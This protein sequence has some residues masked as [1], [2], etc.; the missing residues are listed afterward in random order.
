M[1]TYLRFT[2]SENTNKNIQY[3][4]EYIFKLKLLLYVSRL[5]EEIR[6]E[7]HQ[8]MFVLHSISATCLIFIEQKPISIAFQTM[9]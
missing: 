3:D 9:Y 6:D 7:Q 5:L 8:L 1:I 2:I 4:L